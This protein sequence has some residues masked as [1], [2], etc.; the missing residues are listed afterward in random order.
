LVSYLLNKNEVVSIAAAIAP[1]AETRDINRRLIKCYLEVY[2]RCPLVVAESRDVKGLYIK[3]R[4]EEILN[5]T[6]I[7]DPYEEPEA[8]EILVNTDF[9]T[10]EASVAKIIAFL[11]ATQ[12][13]PQREEGT[14]NHYSEEDE[15][16]WPQGLVSL[17]FCKI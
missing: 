11:E 14:I 1:D 8:P 5:F 13:I 4:A 7:S 3:A 6:G 9:E 17:G 2:C 16:R 15:L 12:L 10:I